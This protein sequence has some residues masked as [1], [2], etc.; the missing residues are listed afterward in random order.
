MKNKT[1]TIFDSIYGVKTIKKIKNLTPQ[2]QVEY[3]RSVFNNDFFVLKC[4]DVIME[5]IEKNVSVLN[6]S[7]TMAGSIK[8]WQDV[9]SKIL[10]S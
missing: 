5:N 6:Y 2:E 8:Y 4:V 7:S 1:K 10:K 3:L 9:K